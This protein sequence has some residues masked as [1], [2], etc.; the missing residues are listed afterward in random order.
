M[1]KLIKVGED[2][3]IPIEEWYAESEEELDAII[4]APTGSIVSILTEDGLKVKMLRST[5]WVEI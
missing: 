1:P 5:G 4:G 3:N 2:N